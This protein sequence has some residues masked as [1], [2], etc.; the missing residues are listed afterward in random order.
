M[1][2]SVL[3]GLRLGRVVRRVVF[4]RLVNPVYRHGGRHDVHRLPGPRVSFH[5]R[6]VRVNAGYVDHGFGALP[7]RHHRTLLH[8]RGRQ[9]VAA[10]LTTTPATLHAVVDGHGQRHAGRHQRL[11]RQRHKRARA[12]RGHRARSPVHAVVVLLFSTH[13]EERQ[14][15]LEHGVAHRPGRRVDRVEQLHAQIDAVHVIVQPFGDQL[16]Q[17]R[18]VG[19]VQRLVGRRRA[20]AAGRTPL[21]N[22]ETRIDLVAPFR[23]QR[24]Q[25][26]QHVPLDAR[27][28]VVVRAPHRRRRRVILRVGGQRGVLVGRRAEIGLIRGCQDVSGQIQDETQRRQKRSRRVHDTDRGGRLRTELTDYVDY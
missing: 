18:R 16:V 2:L 14:Y 4:R 21:V 6:R 25:E 5:V 27:H 12:H 9:V 28:R 15:P 10:S 19:R 8:Q 7:V 20:V 17:P 22:R 1:R 26:H 3:S 13:P 11:A 23:V 24:V